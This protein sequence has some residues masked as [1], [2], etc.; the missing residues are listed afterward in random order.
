LRN[1]SLTEAWLMYSSATCITHRLMSKRSDRSAATEQRRYHV[2]PVS[3][4][5]RR[6]HVKPVSCQQPTW[7]HDTNTQS[8]CPSLFVLLFQKIDF[9]L[10]YIFTS[11]VSSSHSFDYKYDLLH[12]LRTIQCLQSQT[13]R[14]HF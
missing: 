11:L 3:C 12:L 7:S 1:R 8:K 10:F 2:K 13:Y 9:F 4:Q 5:Q 6:S 14:M